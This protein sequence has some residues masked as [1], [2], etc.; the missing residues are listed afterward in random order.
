MLPSSY[1]NG[2]GLQSFRLSGLPVR[3]LSLRPGD[4][5]TT[6]TMAVSMGFRSSVSLLPAI[7]T[8]GLWLLPRR[9]CPPLNAPAFAGRTSVHRVFPQYGS[10][11][12]CPQAHGGPSRCDSIRA[13]PDARLRRCYPR[14]DRRFET[15]VTVSRLSVRA[16]HFHCLL[17]SPEAL[18]PAALCC[19]RPSS[20]AGL[21][22]PVCCSPFHFPP[23]S[24][25]RSGPWHSRIILPEQHTFRAFTVELS[26]I[27]AFN[28]RREPAAC[29]SQFLPQQHWPS[30]RRGKPLALRNPATNF[31]LGG[32]SAISPFALATALLVVSLIRELIVDVPRCS[33]GSVA[34]TGDHRLWRWAEED[35]GALL[36]HRRP[37]QPCKLGVQLRR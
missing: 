37:P 6:L 12:R 25:Y 32:I 3:S 2:L 7:Q 14:F 16:V 13:Q 17:L 29:T 15:A 30:G 19:P 34:Q 1:G 28:F 4:S 11:L 5:S 33:R 24:G 9:V 21:I 8:T 23:S 20:L 35:V 10:K 26:R 36:L 18:A 31:P 27:A 22:R